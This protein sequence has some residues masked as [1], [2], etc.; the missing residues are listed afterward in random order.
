MR[1]LLRHLMPMRA[2]IGVD[3]PKLNQANRAAKLERPSRMAMMEWRDG[4]DRRI[5][6][7]GD[8]LSGP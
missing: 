4:L 8:P 2:R 5:F 3:L 1:Q 7:R 6:M